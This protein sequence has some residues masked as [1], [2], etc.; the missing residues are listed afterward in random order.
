LS[1]SEF[2]P[3]RVAGDWY[4]LDENAVPPEYTLQPRTGRFTDPN[5]WSEEEQSVAPLVPDQADYGP[6]KPGDSTTQ[7]KT[8]PE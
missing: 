1:S 2:D 7:F 4:K 3:R 6:R 8:R 5:V